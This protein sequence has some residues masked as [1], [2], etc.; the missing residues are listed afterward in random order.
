[1]CFI[2]DQ[3]DSIIVQT[4]SN[5]FNTDLIN[6]SHVLIAQLNQ[7]FE[8]MTENQIERVIIS[9]TNNLNIIIENL[10]LKK[11]DIKN[12]IIIYNILIYIYIFK[13]F[14]ITLSPYNKMI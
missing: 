10:N 8:D 12:L 4:M 1:M 13:W 14:Y 3:Y 9:S 2:T 7:T 11:F 5:D 6:Q